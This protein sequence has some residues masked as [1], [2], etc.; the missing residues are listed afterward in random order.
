[1]SYDY[2]PPQ[3]NGDRVRKYLTQGE[4]HPIVIDPLSPFAVPAIFDPIRR[5]R[6]VRSTTG[7]RK[8]G[9]PNKG[10]QKARRRKMMQHGL[11]NHAKRVRASRRP[12]VSEETKVV[13][14]RLLKLV[15][16]M[17]R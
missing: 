17:R 1:M 14:R 10:H 16:E 9:R 6:T 4:E 5:T 12:V 13:T 8:K 3:V 11:T 15:E 2:P 7:R